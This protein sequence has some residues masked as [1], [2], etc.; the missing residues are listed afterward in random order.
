MFC[1]LKFYNFVPKHEFLIQRII[2][3]WKSTFLPLGLSCYNF[4]RD[5]SPF[6]PLFLKL[7]LK[8]LWFINWFSITIT[9]SSFFF[10][11]FLFF[12]KNLLI[13]IFPAFLLICFPVIINLQLFLI[14]QLLPFSSFLFLFYRNNIISAF[15]G[16]LYYLYSHK[17][18]L[19]IW[20]SWPL[21]HKG[22]SL[23]SDDPF[24]SVF[25]GKALKCCWAAL[26]T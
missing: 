22:F 15:F 17:D 12:L 4:C 3:V 8:K 2:S 9:F 19:P 24:W 6:F 20:Y 1:M 23:M 14:L 10:V 13:F 21:L 18:V 11:F 16:S 26:H 25:K 7:V 5:S